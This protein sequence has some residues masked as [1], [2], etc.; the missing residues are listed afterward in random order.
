M[1][2]ISQEI[3]VLDF[4]DEKQSQYLKNNE[5]YFSHYDKGQYVRVGLPN[6]K[7]SN[8]AHFVLFVNAPF[9]ISDTQSSA[10]YEYF[11]QFALNQGVMRQA[12]VNQFS[13]DTNFFSP[14]FHLHYFS[15]IPFFPIFLI[16]N[17]FFNGQLLMP[18]IHHVRTTTK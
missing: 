7:F 8:K 5:A 12:Y 6:M 1:T 17:V 2:Q 3:L 10:I 14:F 4:G 11:A 18:A 16:Q 15:K 13:S 9:K